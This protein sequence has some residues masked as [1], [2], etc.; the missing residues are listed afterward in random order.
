MAATLPV[1]RL[2]VAEAVAL[3]QIIQQVQTAQQIAALVAVV[4]VVVV[5]HQREVQVAQE[6]S[7]LTQ[8]LLLHRLQVR[9]L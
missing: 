6:L 8:A 7:L 2:E 9:Q 1:A 3:A 4:L 5:A